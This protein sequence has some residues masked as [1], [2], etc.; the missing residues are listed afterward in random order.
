VVDF[1]IGSTTV[2]AASKSDFRSTPRNGHRQTAP[3]GPIGAIS[4]HTQLDC[5]PD[6]TSPAL[7]ASS[8]SFVKIFFPAMRPDSQAPVI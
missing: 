2:P 8:A 4:E 5:G 7:R 3:S 6:P 1:R